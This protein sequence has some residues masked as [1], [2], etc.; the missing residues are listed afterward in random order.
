MMWAVALL[1]AVVDAAIF[2]SLH[3]S[4]WLVFGV[5]FFWLSFVPNIGM[6]ISIVL[7]MPLVLLDPVTHPLSRTRTR[8]LIFA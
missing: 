8:T 2:W 6:A 3:L 7:P 4:L 1:V 5:L